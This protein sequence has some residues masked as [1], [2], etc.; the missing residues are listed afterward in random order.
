LGELPGHPWLQLEFA[1][2]IIITARSCTI[3]SGSKGGMEHWRKIFEGGKKKLM[4]GSSGK[5]SLLV[6]LM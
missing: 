4:N 5:L 6:K 3:V 1:A 2:T